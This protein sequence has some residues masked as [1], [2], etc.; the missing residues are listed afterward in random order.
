MSRFVAVIGAE[1]AASEMPKSVIF[2]TPA[3]LISRLAGLMSRWISPAWCAASRPA[4][5]WARTLAVR[6]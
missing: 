6:A 3:G 5:A 4:A 2:T 1:S